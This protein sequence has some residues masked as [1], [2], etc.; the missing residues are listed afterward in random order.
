MHTYIKTEPYRRNSGMTLVE[1]M[2]AA[3]LGVVVLGVAAGFT[4]AFMRASYKSMA[5]IENGIQQWGLSAKLQIDGKIAD[6]STIFQSATQGTPE[7]LVTVPI[8]NGIA[9]DGLERGKVLVLSKSII[10]SAGVTTNVI[11][12]LVFYLY[13]PGT[14]P[15]YGTLKRF[16]AKA[17]DTF[18]VPVGQRLDGTGA[19]QTVRALVNQNINTFLGGAATIQKHVMSVA[20]NKGPFAHF[21]NTNNVSIALVRIETSGTL[22]TR[23]LTEVS[24]NLR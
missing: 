20:G 1:V 12:D 3:S 8:D 14:A 2:V 13:T 11:S 7:Y 10:D 23:N 15:E 17:P 16:P 9:A 24:F 18:S 19:P 21:G 5:D 22:E 6:G 4:F